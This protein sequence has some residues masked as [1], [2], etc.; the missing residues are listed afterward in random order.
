[1][2]KKP[3]KNII[4]NNFI[5]NI[6]W[7]RLSNI[8]I[9]SFKWEGIESTGNERLTSRLIEMTLFKY[10]YGV[11]MI[12]EDKLIFLPAAVSGD[13]NLYFEP[14]SFYLIGNT[15]NIPR[16]VL[17]D[18]SV[19][20]R[21]VCNNMPTIQLVDYY[22]GQLSSIQRAQDVNLFQSK[23]QLAVEADEDSLFSLKNAI[24]EIDANQLVLYGKK[25][26]MSAVKT[27]DIKFNYLL[28][29]YGDYKL[30]ILNEFLQTFG[31]KNILT[32]KRERLTQNEANSSDEITYDGY[33]GAMLDMRIDAC[34][35]VNKLFG[36]NLTVKLNR[37]HSLE[38]LIT[39]TKVE[40]LG[41]NDIEME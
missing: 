13:L 3:S 31:Y 33:V 28:D 7:D 22:A 11:F 27:L 36:M 24:A 9:N 30:T 41:G 2:K 38:K 25:D 26:I 16:A 35:Q 15:A 23:L 29:K 1:M 32:Q 39:E 4:K 37:D 21:N 6:W 12:W 10:G 14:T 20:C 17:E 5:Y 40:N 8:I 19:L 18:N 34:K